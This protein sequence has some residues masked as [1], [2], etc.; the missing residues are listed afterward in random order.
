MRNVLAVIG[1]VMLLSS[2]KK[3]ATEPVAEIAAQKPV[4]TRSRAV[5]DFASGAG[6]GN[7]AAVAPPPVAPEPRMIV[8]TASLSLIVSDAH[9][10]MDAVTQT[11]SQLGGY[12][13]ESK[14]W[15]ENDQMRGTVTVRVP[16]ARFDEMIGT[17]KKSSVRVQSETSSGQDVTQ[18]FSDLG[19][20]LRNAEA[21]EHELRELLTTV[22]QRTQRANDVLE[23][24][25]RLSEVRGQ[26]EQLKGRMQYL[27]QVSAMS[28]ITFEL[29]P[30]VITQ[31][32]VEQSWSARDVAHGA[33]RNLISLLQ[34]LAEIGISAAIYLTPFLLLLLLAIAS[35][36]RFRRSAA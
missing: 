5:A 6:V 18:E 24:F 36:R 2:C 22:R 30:D 28:A 1:I 11:A 20:Q 29:V 31:P 35:I 27:S 23:V 10:A 3:E 12:V 17:A 25:A 13:T 16:S 14:Q 33:V 15:R 9:K 19:A 32:V 8:R 26:I 7:S 4:V 34:W 21:A